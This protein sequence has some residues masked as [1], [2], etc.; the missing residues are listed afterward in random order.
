M[1]IT[2]VESYSGKMGVYFG[3]LPG[4]VGPEEARKAL[5]PD[6][7]R[8]HADADENTNG[9]V[10]GAGAGGWAA[11]VSHQEHTDEA[12][13]KLV[14]AIWVEDGDPRWLQMVKAHFTEMGAWVESDLT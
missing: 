9:A 10:V 4:H 11:L 2:L 8:W 6:V 12:W 13:E 7:V 3:V 5:F 14:K 1:K